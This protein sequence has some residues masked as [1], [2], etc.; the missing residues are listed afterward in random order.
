MRN[1]EITILYRV[2]RQGFFDKVKLSID[3]KEERRMV[4]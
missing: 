3:L 1:R 2:V 4:L